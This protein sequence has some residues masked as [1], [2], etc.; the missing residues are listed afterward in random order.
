MAFSSPQ[1]RILP[2]RSRPYTHAESDCASIPQSLSAHARYLDAQAISDCQI[3]HTKLYTRYSPIKSCASSNL[4]IC[5]LQCGVYPS[6]KAHPSTPPAQL[7]EHHEIGS[8]PSETVLS[9]YYAY[10]VA[11]L[12]RPCTFE[13]T[14]LARGGV[15]TV[16][17][18][19]GK[20]PKFTCS[21]TS[22]SPLVESCSARYQ[23]R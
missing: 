7:V 15:A 1:T 14:T 3:L 20:R 13:W 10:Y 17:P 23:G 22:C 21:C 4:P 11:H 12:C 5:S 16:L 6:Q 8:S 9:A 2:S 19:G 18:G